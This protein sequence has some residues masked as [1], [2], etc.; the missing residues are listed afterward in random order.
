[1]ESIENQIV[2]YLLLHEELTDWIGQR[3]YPLELLEGT[4]LPAMV[5]SRTSTTKNNRARNGKNNAPIIEFSVYANRYSEI[6]AITE[7][8][9]HI[10]DQVSL[11]LPEFGLVTMFLENSRDLNERDSGLKRQIIEIEANY[12]N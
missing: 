11:E 10:T 12:G 9:E 1:M 3:L 8:F 5:Y 7:I 4:Q 2:N 6:K